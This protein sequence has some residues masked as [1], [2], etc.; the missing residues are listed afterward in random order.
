MS[1]SKYKVVYFNGRGLGEV[2]RCLFALADVAY[3]DY[4]YPLSEKYE[5]PE[6]DAD[7]SKYPFEKLPVLEVDGV[8]IPQSKAM[9]RF[10]ARRF[11]FLGAND[12]EAALIDGVT[13]ELSDARSKFMDARKGNTE[14]EKKE[15]FANFINKELPPFYINLERWAAKNSSPHFVGSKI[16]LADLVFW[17]QNSVIASQPQVTAEVFAK[18]LNNYPHLKKIHDT[19]DQN[20]KIKSWI[21]RRPKTFV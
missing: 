17:Y 13:E 4:R 10:L 20:D 19:V 11:G 3:E 5:R 6:W 1:D 7:K 16:S 21:E 18:F 14:E 2:S 9:E 12:I 8:V 15:N